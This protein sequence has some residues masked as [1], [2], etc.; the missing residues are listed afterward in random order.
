MKRLL[1]AALLLLIALPGLAGCAATG[2]PLNLAHQAGA[3]EVMP[4]DEAA[5]AAAVLAA[6][7]AEAAAE[8]KLVLAIFGANWCHDSRALAGQLQSPELAPF[9]DANFK[10]AYID[11]G[12]PQAGEGRNLDLATKFGVEGIRGTPTMLVLAPAGTLLNTPEDA[13]GWRN[14]AGLSAAEVRAALAG[15]TG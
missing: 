15:Y 11:A 8:D 9:V 14:A 7:F 1:R 2:G 12:M 6:A 5:D 4:Y 13:K 3:P 10:V